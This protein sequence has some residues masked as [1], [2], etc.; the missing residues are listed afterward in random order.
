MKKILLLVPLL[1]WAGCGNPYS[2]FYVDL[3]GGEDILNSP[4]VVLST[5][6]PKLVQGSNIEQDNLNMLENCYLL[7]GT[8]NF[9]AEGVSA[10]LAIEHARKIHAD[11]VVVYGQYTNTVSGAVPLTLPN[12]AERRP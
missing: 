1:L 5:G 4:Q 6:A 9:N 8:S 11:T 2:Q 10:N 7:L 3:T 12:F